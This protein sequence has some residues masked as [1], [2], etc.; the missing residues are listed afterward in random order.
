MEVQRSPLLWPSPLGPS[1]HREALAALRA[2]QSLLVFPG[3]ARERLGPADVLQWRSR[4]AY[5]RLALLTQTPVVPVAMEGADQQH[6]VRL[7]LEGGRAAFLP[8]I[9]LPVKLTFRFGPAMAPPARGDTL[10]LS[11]F[12]EEVAHAA[13][14]LLAGVRERRRRR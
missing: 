3:G 12:A 4:R 11:A 13:R 6:V 1:P 14:L 2:G 10:A 8:P 9:P 7:R 5:A